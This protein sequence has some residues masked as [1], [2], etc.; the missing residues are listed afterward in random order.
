MQRADLQVKDDLKNAV[1]ETAWSI[2]ENTRTMKMKEEKMRKG[3]PEVKFVW[4]GS[5][6]KVST[7]LWVSSW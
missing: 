2:W 5:V 6:E 1:I 4:V 3:N 7:I